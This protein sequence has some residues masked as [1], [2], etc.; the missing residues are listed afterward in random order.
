M[1]EKNRRGLLTWF[2]YRNLHL[3][4]KKYIYIKTYIHS[5][6]MITSLLLNPLYYNEL[7]DE[8]SYMLYS[9]MLNH[10]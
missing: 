9:Y 10:D 1:R 2:D 4:K 7:I 5:G 8:Y 6:K 3:A